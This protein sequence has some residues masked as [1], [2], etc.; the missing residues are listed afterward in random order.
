MM[1]KLTQTTSKNGKRQEMWLLSAV[2]SG[3]PKR[4]ATVMPA[5]MMETASEPCR[6]S[7]SFMATMEATPK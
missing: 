5:I 3:T 1:S 4:F 2:P 7:A 6:S